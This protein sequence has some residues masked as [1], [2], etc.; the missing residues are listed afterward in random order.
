MPE[1]VLVVV[2]VLVVERSVFSRRAGFHTCLPYPGHGKILSS[3]WTEIKTWLLSN[4]CGASLFRHSEVVLLGER[5]LLADAGAEGVVERDSFAGAQ[6]ALVE[7]EPELVERLLALA[8]V[9]DL[10]AIREQALHVVEVAA[11]ECGQAFQIADAAIGAVGDQSRPP[12]SRRNVARRMSF[13]STATLKP[14]G[15]RQRS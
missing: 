11:V 4:D 8:Q 1:F 9:N 12:S 2:L 7:G 10:D 13:S 6:P 15:R 5:E 3:A 14:L